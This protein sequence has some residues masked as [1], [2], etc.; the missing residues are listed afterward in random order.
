M[1]TVQASLT[2]LRDERTQVL[3]DNARLKLLAD[4]AK[5]QLL[6]LQQQ[7]TAALGSLAAARHE[8]QELQVRHEN[9]LSEVAAE[10]LEELRQLEQEHQEEMEQLSARLHRAENAAGKAAAEKA[11][12]ANL[13]QQQQQQQAEIERERRSAEVEEVEQQ[14]Q[15]QQPPQR[16][17]AAA[18]P[19][20][21]THASISSLITHT[22]R[23]LAGVTPQ[24]SPRS[25]AASSASPKQSTHLLPLWKE[26]CEAEESA[27]RE[28][29]E[30]EP[31][32][33]ALTLD[34]QKQH[35]KLQDPQAAHVFERIVA[36]DVARAANVHSACVKVEAMRA[37]DSSVI[38]ELEIARP[39]DGSVVAADIVTYLA[40]QL[41]DAHSALREGALSQFAAAVIYE[42]PVDALRRKYCEDVLALER[43]VMAAGELVGQYQ[44]EV[45]LLKH[46]CTELQSDLDELLSE[47]EPQLQ[48]E[49]E[50][51]RVPETAARERAAT[52]G[53]GGEREKGAAERERGARGGAGGGGG[54]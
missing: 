25:N 1:V 20:S 36:Q 50:T 35:E 3:A 10:Q 52:E 6:L 12:A 17:A 34:L 43:E 2:R 51:Q 33:F 29:A 11:A 23:M 37:T 53:Q 28:Q 39:A 18:P 27:L 47:R 5:S 46:K 48:R 13:L 4:N 54:M 16:A 45:L 44:N 24:R 38:V 41:R 42:R 14:Q 26:M 31:A 7:L 40:L 30:A 22:E 19:A 49:R 32:K 21:P 9:T 15:Q 8:V